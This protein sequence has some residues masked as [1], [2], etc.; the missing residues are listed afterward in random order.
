M[1]REFY[2]HVKGER[3]WIIVTVPGAAQVT[4]QI[5]VRVVVTA[6]AGTI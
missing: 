3:I 2:L 5:P 1:K 6:P 4:D